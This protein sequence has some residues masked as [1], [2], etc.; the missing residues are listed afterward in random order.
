MI[1]PPKDDGVALE[2]PT[3]CVAS[4]SELPK[5]AFVCGV[6]PKVKPPAPMLAAGR[7]VVCLL[8][9]DEK[10]DDEDADS[11]ENPEDEEE[12]VDAEGSVEEGNTDADD[13]E[14]EEDAEDAVDS[15]SSS[16]GVSHAAHFSS[17]IGFLTAHEEHL[18]VPSSI[19]PNNSHKL[20]PPPAPSSSSS[21]S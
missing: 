13:D 1:D 10:D 6:A 3:V 7:G 14:D 21:S 17:S 2:S 15:G 16:L 9:A 20:F 4:E 19:F 18:H 8:A 11:K 12:E 5:V